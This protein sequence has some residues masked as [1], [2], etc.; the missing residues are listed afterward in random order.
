[1]PQTLS[2]RA[3]MTLGKD[4]TFRDFAQGAFRMRAVGSGQ[5][6]TLL[7]TPQARAAAAAAP[8]NPHARCPHLPHARR[9]ARVLL[10]TRPRPT[11]H[12]AGGARAVVP[13]TSRARAP[14]QF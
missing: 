10:R 13:P 2:A 8:P 14:C 5:T 11:D 6:I 1:M 4:M 7:I 3:A 9:R 12:R